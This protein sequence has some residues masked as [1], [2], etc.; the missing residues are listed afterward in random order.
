MV[1]LLDTSTWILFLK[2][3]NINLLQKMEAVAPEEVATCSVVKAELWYGALKYGN[4]ERRRTTVSEL[5]EPY[6]SLPFDENSIDAY[7]AIRH[8]LDQRGLNIGPNDLMI[9]AIARAH[10][11][12]L[13]STNTREFSRVADLQVE[14]WTR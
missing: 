3:A 1:Y 7:A 13:V 2:G 12:T 5:L 9:A 14:D 8:D 11:L 6:R 4:P 10:S